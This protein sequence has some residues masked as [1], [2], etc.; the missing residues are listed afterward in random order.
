MYQPLSANEEGV[1]ASEVF[2]GLQLNTT[3]LL[4]GDMATVLATLQEGMKQPSYQ[5]FLEQLQNNE[6]LD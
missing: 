1:I 4:D 5:S 3:A 6:H 2:P